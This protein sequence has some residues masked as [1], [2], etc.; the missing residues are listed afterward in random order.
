MS[1]IYDEVIDDDELL[2]EP[3]Q[4]TPVETPVEDEPTPPTPPTVLVTV[5]D[6]N[7]YT[8]NYETSTAVD[9]LKAQIIVAAEEVVSNYLGF[10]PNTDELSDY[11]SGIGDN[12]LYLKAWPIKQVDLVQVNGVEVPSTDYSVCG[13][14]RYLRL[15]QGVWPVGV[16]NIRVDYTAGWSVAEMPAIIKTTILQIAA[17]MLQETGGNIGITGKSFSESSRSFV[18]YT[19]Y[20]KWLKKLDPLRIVRLI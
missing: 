11:V 8:G 12:H 9:E 13:E 5:A 17:L 20:D 15:N 7:T 2:D 16:E 18:N 1:D 10:D 6:F 19:N 4:D 3:S 14:G